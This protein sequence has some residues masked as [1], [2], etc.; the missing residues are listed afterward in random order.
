MQALDKGDRDGTVS[1]HR[2]VVGPCVQDPGKC[3]FLGLEGV[4]DAVEVGAAP[5]GV[6]GTEQ[7]E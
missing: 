4:V 3:T 7:I 2:P 1:V 5:G 6:D